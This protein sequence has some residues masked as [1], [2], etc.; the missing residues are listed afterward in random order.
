MNNKKYTNNQRHTIM[1][2]QRKEVR[3]QI[4]SKQKNENCEYE[5]F[6]NFENVIIDGESEMTRHD[7]HEKYEGYAEGDSLDMNLAQGKTQS[8][9]KRK[10]D[11][12]MHS[13]MHVD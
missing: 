9:N 1:K 10:N 7:T 12:D 11:D 8:T 3:K 13:R 4:N 5:T 2:N 6:Y